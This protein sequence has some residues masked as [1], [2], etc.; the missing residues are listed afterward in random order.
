MLRMLSCALLGM[1]L[2]T[3]AAS[4]P[5][6]MR[7][8]MYDDGLACPGGCDAHVVFHASNNGT[9]RAFAPD[10]SRSAPQRCTPGQECR[11]CFGSGDD[12]CM[13]VRYRGGGPPRDAFD[14]TPAFFS[15]RCAESAIPAALRAKCG[16]LNRALQRQGDKVYCVSE[17]THP[18]C[19]AL[20]AA[21]TAAAEADRPLREA[22]LAAGESR[23]NAAQTDPARRRSAACNY[24]LNGTGRNSAG[25]TWRRLLPAACRPGSYVGRDGLDCCGPDLV[26]AVGF[27]RFECAGFLVP[28]Q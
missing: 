13:T 17:P 16:E 20:I 15:D 22:C 26:S 24:E 4:Q 19:V 8:T 25:V 11:I 14:F 12:T 7:I 3:A 6:T 5:A 23:F 9:A 1:A 2:A 28:R 27:G 10:S 21:A 18:Q